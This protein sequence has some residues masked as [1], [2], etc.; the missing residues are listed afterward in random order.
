MLKRAYYFLLIILISSC[1]YTAV[2]HKK[3]MFANSNGWYPSDFDPKTQV[4]LIEDNSNNPYE[5]TLKALSNYAYKYEFY[6][7]I[8]EL[9][10]NTKYE[11]TS[12]YKYALRFKS[13]KVRYSGTKDYPASTSVYCDYYFV[14][15]SDH[16]EFPP[17]G[18]YSG[19]G[20]IVLQSIVKY[21]NAK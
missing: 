18:Y 21:I 7:N 4:L 10:H 11:D 8:A 14:R 6:N 19:A 15:L 5:K 12:V 9:I 3:M 2:G 13:W 17:T 1:A 20:Y 16:H